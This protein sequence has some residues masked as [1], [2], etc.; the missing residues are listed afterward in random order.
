MDLEPER[1]EQLLSLLDNESLL[2]AEYPKLAEYLDVAP[3]LSG[4]GDDER[5]GEFELRMIEV[6]TRSSASA[7]NPYWE[8]VAPAVS[9]VGGRRVVDGGHPN[10]SARLA[11]AQTVLQDA[12][13]FAVIAPETVRWMVGTSGNGGVMELGAGR[14][15]WAAQLEH[16]GIKVDAYDIE[17]PSSVRGATYAASGSR[18]GTWTKV[19]N[20]AELEPSEMGSRTLLLCWPP[21]WGDTM[22]SDILKTFE[23]AGGEKLIYVGEP[24]GGKTGDDL[25]FDG[26]AAR[27]RMDSEDQNFVSWW[28]NSDLAQAWTRVGR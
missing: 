3:S 28:N 5:D 6:L 15:Y 17:P 26:L 16:S 19:H 12:Y 25:F 7:Q 18:S 13:A 23:D 24:R 14:G 20:L 27:W 11:F 2:K 22:A 10:G 1:R 8:I 21:G 9:E 4:T